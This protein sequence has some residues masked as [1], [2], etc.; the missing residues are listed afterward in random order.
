MSRGQARSNRQVEQGKGGGTGRQRQRQRAKS[1]EGLSEV[2]NT[3]AAAPQHEVGRQTQPE[4]TETETERSSLL[5]QGK[6]PAA[7]A[8]SKSLMSNS[9]YS[10]PSSPPQQPLL[11]LQLT[12]F[13]MSRA[14]PA[15]AVSSPRAQPNDAFIE[16][17]SSTRPPPAL[18]I[19]AATCS[20]TFQ[21][22]QQVV[23]KLTFNKGWISLKPARGTSIRGI[24]Q[25]PIL[26]FKINF[27]SIDFWLQPGLD[28]GHNADGKCD[29]KEWLLGANTAEH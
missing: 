10:S 12:P 17:T 16:A 24:P 1:K 13:V 19:A 2:F 7:A 8:A 28:F 18:I 14:P 26:N 22:S 20:S 23:S 27:E 11:P 5:H 25:V 6:R 9:N 15:T 3:A 29:F 21:F 4:E